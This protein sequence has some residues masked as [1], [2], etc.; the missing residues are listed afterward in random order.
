MGLG[1]SA[2]AWR[3]LGDEPGI[4]H[5]A[6]FFRPGP[7]VLLLASTLVV[8]G[9]APF[10]ARS[11]LGSL[12]RIRAG[13]DRRSG[14]PNPVLAGAADPLVLPS[15]AWFQPLGIAAHRSRRA[16][17]VRVL[18]MSPVSGRGVSVGLPLCTGWSGR[19]DGK[20]SQPLHRH[21]PS[22]CGVSFRYYRFSPASRL[23]PR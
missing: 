22:L 4:E 5:L 23:L 20:L 19:L 11:P 9:N 18:S 6:P 17:S 15:R 13:G 7:L 12:R 16:W 10:R 3:A 21:A 8:E 14:T 1:S 2:G